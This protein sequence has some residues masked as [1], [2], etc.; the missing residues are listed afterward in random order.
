MT[1]VTDNWI[2][3]LLN[4]YQQSFPLVTRPFHHIAGELKVSPEAVLRE[5]TLLLADRTISRIGPVF[6]PNTIGA[7]TLAA[8]AVP[9]AELE[10]AA[11]LVNAY[12]EV[13][14]NYEREHRLNLWFVIT[15]GSQ[16]DIR[17]VL[18]DIRI[19]TGY[20]VI[21]LPLVR[22][23][24]IDLG[25]AL[26]GDGPDMRRRLAKA[27]SAPVPIFVSE[28][29]LRLIRVLQHGLP[30]VERPY[31]ECGR[32][33]HLSETDTIN[34]V[35]GL[36]ESGVVKRFGVVVRHHELGY[37]ANA[38]V[39]WTLP[40]A[41]ADEVGWRLGACADVTLCYRRRPAPPAWTHNLFCM[42]HGKVRTQVLERIESLTCHFGLSDVPRDVLFS[43]RRF[44]QRG[45]VYPVGAQ[46]EAITA[47]G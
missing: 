43:R 42:I 20:Q 12:P 47:C 2:D 10:A 27:P 15:A 46:R 5:M 23:Y 29:D 1:P 30:L 16:L 9:E 22:D 37:R 17:R 6:R 26:N 13:N 8:M 40:D 21:S 24:H 11:G 36:Q 31:R 38:M 14:H 32:F 44:K 39:A 41:E 33:A 4:D 19:R 25:F 35:R 3:R 34:A 45:A 18:T 7:S 28:R